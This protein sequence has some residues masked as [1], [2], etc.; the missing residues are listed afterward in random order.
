[1]SDWFIFPLLLLAGWLLGHVLLQNRPLTPPHNEKWHPLESLFARLVLGLLLIGW[2]AFFLAEVGWFSLGALAAIW[3]AAVLLLFAAS[4]R[5]AVTPATTTSAEPASPPDA[6]FAGIKLPARLEYVLLA[7]WLPAAVWLFFRPHEAVLGGA[8]AGVYLSTAAHVAES[9]QLLMQDE[10]L[11]TLDPAL[12]SALLRERRAGE[13]TPYY[14]YP[15]FNVV[16]EPAGRVIPDFFHLHPTWQAV[17]YAAGGVRAALLMTG[18]WALLGSLA[19]YFAVR[20]FSNWPVAMLTLFGLTANAMQVWFA[21]YPV[22]EMLTQFLLWSGLWAFSA[23]LTGRRPLSLWGLLAGLALGQLFL[24]RIDTLFLLAIPFL[25][26]LWLLL[27][28]EWR[29]AQLWF[30]VPVAA[31]VLHTAVH[32]AIFSTPYFYRIGYYIGGVLRRLGAAPVALVAVALLLFLLALRWRDRIDLYRH[33]RSLLALG[34]LL[35]LVLAGYGWF[36]RPVIGAVPT[37]TEWYDGSTIVVTDR[38]NLRRLGWYLGLPGVWLGAFGACL[39]LWRLNRKNV[40]IIGVGLFFSLVY[41]WRIQATPHQIYAMRR[42]VP[43]TLPFFIL[44]AAYLLGW[45]AQQRRP[46]LRAVGLLLIPIWLAG[47]LLSARGFITHV[48][49]QGLTEQVAQLAERVDEQALFIFND[50]APVSMGDLL[51]TPLHYLH[52]H[53]AFTLRD[54]AAVDDPRLAEQVAKW[55]AQGFTVYWV[56]NGAPLEQQRWPYEQEETIEINYTYLE[57]AYEHKPTRLIPARWVLPLA[58]LEELRR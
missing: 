50:P 49:A 45:L 2:L 43:A 26:A 6:T 18:L 16:L 15:G 23:W 38:E 21:R 39:L 53:D 27:R 33:R 51:G 13:G 12:Y 57:N 19:V 56:G 36:V 44:C 1:M 5:M 11:A 48:D 9:G 14:L 31:L 40:A 20:Q 42:Y 24:T 55:Q 35:I 3:L 22:T 46:W 32:G 30:F 58:R 25:A 54:V 28:R 34:A 52:G 17:A 41:L 47:L 10:T 29:P 8:D 7:L 37:Y 4:R